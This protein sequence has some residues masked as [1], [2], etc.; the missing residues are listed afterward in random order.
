MTD[1]GF[2]LFDTAIGR[3]GIAWKGRGIGAA[4]L[5]GRDEPKTRARLL[6]R[7]PQAWEEAPPPAVRQVIDRI[8]ALLAGQAADLS[9]VTLDMEGVPPFNRGVY[10]VARTIPP[11]Q[12]L[13]YGEI[14]ARLGAPEEARAVGQGAGANPVSAAR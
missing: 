6:R 12:T 1:S 7:C 8:V 9:D 2:T 10:E 5:R 4:K 3:C 14:A 13:T 11:G